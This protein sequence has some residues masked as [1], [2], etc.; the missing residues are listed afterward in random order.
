MP[1]HHSTEQM[2][3]EDGDEERKH[4]NINKM[5]SILKEWSSCFVAQLRPTEL[6]RFSSSAKFRQLS[7]HAASTF[8]AVDTRSFPESHRTSPAPAGSSGCWQCNEL[9][10]AMKCIPS[11]ADL[12]L[13]NYIRLAQEAT[14]DA[15][16]QVG[17]P[18]WQQQAGAWT[19]TWTLPWSGRGRAGVLPCPT[20]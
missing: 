6:S 7:Q 10:A 15:T 9:H 5:S 3:R 8:V 20:R 17:A 18:V 14:N 13:K 12:L 4:D 2:L 16:P 19:L 11:A 1:S